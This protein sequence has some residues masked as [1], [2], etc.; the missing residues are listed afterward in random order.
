MDQKSSEIPAVKK[1]LDEKNKSISEWLER[2]GTLGKVV[3]EPRSTDV[4]DPISL[5]DI[6]EYYS[7]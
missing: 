6:V 7:R 3:R 1:S 2:K 4:F 5:Q